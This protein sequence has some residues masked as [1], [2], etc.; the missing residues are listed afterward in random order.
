MND[1][2]RAFY[3]PWLGVYLWQ[4]I[5]TN[6]LSEWAL[7]VEIEDFYDWCYHNTPHPL[8]NSWTPARTH[9]NVWTFFDLNRR[10]EHVATRPLTVN[11]RNN[12]AL[13]P[14]ITRCAED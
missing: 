5:P 10:I 1:I 13:T 14:F 8:L 7:L 9:S 3:C 12:S 2:D 11:I 6:T 4:T